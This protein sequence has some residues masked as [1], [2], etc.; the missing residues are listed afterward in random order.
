MSDY[1]GYRAQGDISR[2]NSAN[3]IPNDRQLYLRRR[4]ERYPGTGDRD[5]PAE[6][7]DLK[8]AYDHRKRQNSSD[9]AAYRSAKSDE[10]EIVA[11]SD[12]YKREY[13]KSYSED[14]LPSGHRRL[15]PLAGQLGQ[16][17][18]SSV[19]SHSS[20]LFFLIKS[21]SH[22]RA[23]E[24]VISQHPLMYTSL[25]SKKTHHKHVRDRYQEAESAYRSQ[26]RHAQLKA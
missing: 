13:Y 5:L 14:I 8:Q 15:E 19:R 2:F 11:S 26:A 24:A 17:A 16:S 1:Q 7:G 21:I 12:H 3:P 4:R 9:R 22:A 6:T 10:L 18:L 25:E 20:Y 23:R